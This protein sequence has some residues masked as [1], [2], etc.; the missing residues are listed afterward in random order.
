MHEVRGSKPVVAEMSFEELE[1]FAFLLACYKNVED[2]TRGIEF[3]QEI[4]LKYKKLFKTNRKGWDEVIASSGPRFLPS[5]TVRYQ[6]S[7]ANVFG[8]VIADDY[9]DPTEEGYNGLH[10]SSDPKTTL[11][12]PRRERKIKRRRGDGDAS[13]VWVHSYERLVQD[14][15]ANAAPDVSDV[16]DETFDEIARAYLSAR[17]NPSGPLSQG[18]KNLTDILSNQGP[19]WNERY[20]KWLKEYEKTAHALGTIPNLKQATS[21]PGVSKR[22]M[23]QA[24]ELIEQQRKAERVLSLNKK[25]LEEARKAQ[26]LA[27]KIAKLTKF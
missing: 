1:A 27:D 19:A 16:P 13:G 12:T 14:A 18:I 26:E 11:Q 25:Q 21:L 2:L 8:I 5:L 4:D 15:L 9:P 20:E 6:E 17:Q 24:Q 7:R 22:T 23:E 3:G 10:S